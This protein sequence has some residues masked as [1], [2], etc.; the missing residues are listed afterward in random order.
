MI[1]ATN[2]STYRLSNAPM[3]GWSLTRNQ[4]IKLAAFIVS[5]LWKRINQLEGDIRAVGITNATIGRA[6]VGRRT[7][8]AKRKW[9]IGERTIC[10]SERL[11]PNED[12]RRPLSVAPVM[13]IGKVIA[14]GRER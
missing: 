11:M 8:E 10:R 12:V 9:P 13:I 6:N 1:A 14:R 5:S 3:W 4:K 7:A 2:A